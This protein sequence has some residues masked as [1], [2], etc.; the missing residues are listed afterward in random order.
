MGFDVTV[1]DVNVGRLNISQEFCS[2]SIKIWNPRNGPLHEKFD[3]CVE[4]T[5]SMSGLQTAIDSTVAGGRVIIGSWFGGSNHTLHLGTAFHRSHITLKASQVSTVPAH[6]S[7]RWPKSR[8]FKVAWNLLRQLRPSR[9]LGMAGRTVAF[10]DDAVSDLEKLS[11]ELTESFNRLERGIDLT[12]LIDYR[13][14]IDHNKNSSTAKV[15]G[16]H[17]T[18]T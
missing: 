18:F 1:V 13:D 15:L 9:L 7:M 4:I 2:A 17:L 3:V 14:H 5:G 10:N 12:T 8:R 6:L 11:E 16:S